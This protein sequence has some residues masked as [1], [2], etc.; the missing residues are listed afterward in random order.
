M[1]NFQVVKISGFVFFAKKTK[2]LSRRGRAIT[3]EPLPW[4]KIVP[5]HKDKSSK[6]QSNLLFNPSIAASCCRSVD[7]LSM[8]APDL[9]IPSHHIIPSYQ[10]AVH[11]PSLWRLLLP[12]QHK[13]VATL[14]LAQPK[15]R[16]WAGQSNPSKI[17]DG[18][19]D[20]FPNQKHKKQRVLKPPTMSIALQ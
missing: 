15:T 12:S 13:I 2:W 10:R 11:H 1:H 18:N 9:T 17:C 16:A 4:T 19:L 8:I 3:G 14:R 7:Y 20:I 6:K 5:I